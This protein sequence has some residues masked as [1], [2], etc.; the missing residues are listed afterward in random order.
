M[1]NPLAG[2]DPSGYL[3]CGTGALEKAECN[4]ERKHKRPDPS[5]TGI[6]AHTLWVH[7]GSA[8]SNGA[9]HSPR[10]AATGERERGAIGGPG[11][12]GTSGKALAQIADHVYG[13]DGATLPE[14]ISQISFEELKRMGLEGIAFN[15]VESG[16]QSSL[17]FDSNA[18]QYIYAFAGTQDGTDWVQNFSQG[19][20][21][22][23]KQYDL[24]IG[25]TQT[26]RDATSGSLHLTGHSLGGGLASAA[27]ILTNTYATTFNAARVNPSTIGRYGGSMSG[28][29]RLISAYYVKGEIL[30]S[31][32]SA[33]GRRIPIDAVNPIKWWHS[34]AYKAY[35][36]LQL[37]GMNEVLASPEWQK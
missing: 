7:R 16:F 12:G 15:D 10:S 14:G 21:Q 6:V 11:E 35:R 17:Y 1:N 9:R 26:I 13:K 5:S 25:H 24:A 23:S 31:L 30:N 28:A 34:P 20:G 27:A 37:H 4:D 22:F 18:N 2:T 32:Q 33:T 3:W 29:N 8:A 19:L 36:S